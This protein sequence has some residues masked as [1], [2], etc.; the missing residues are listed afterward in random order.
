MYIKVICFL[1]EFVVVDSHH[2]WSQSIP[3]YVDIKYYCHLV[4]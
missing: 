4:V 1:M 3:D 2:Q